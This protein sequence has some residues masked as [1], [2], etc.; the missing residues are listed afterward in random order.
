[1]FS[2]YLIVEY[3]SYIEIPRRSEAVSEVFIN[4]DVERTIQAMTYF[5][6]L[7]LDGMH[8]D[9]SMF[10]MV[11]STSPVVL[12]ESRSSK[13]LVAVVDSHLTLTA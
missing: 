10:P 12:C 9:V 4:F 11:Q 7:N 13:L 3:C 5:A 2:N 6:A 8:A 1:M